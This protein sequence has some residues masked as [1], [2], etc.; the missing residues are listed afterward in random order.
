[1]IRVHVICEGQT[2]EMFVNEMLLPIFQPKGIVLVPALLGEPG[3]KGGNVKI[4][5]VVKDVRLRL[6]SDTTAYCT[7][8]IDF[9]GIST[10]F[11]GYQEASRMNQHVTKSEII[12]SEMVKVIEAEVG[13]NAMRRFIPYIQM[14]EFEAL[15]FSEPSDFAS[16][17]G[18]PDL[19]D[20]LRDIRNSFRSPEE[21]N[22]SPVTAPSK[23][24]EY[25]YPEF[26]KPIHGTFGTLEIGIDKIRTECPLFSG[27]LGQIENLTGGAMK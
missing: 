5:R 21:I 26:E 2:E 9:Y 17:I 15:L 16:A 14:Y 13:Q 22:D 25:L 4:E 1:M 11:P 10:N 8:L 6:L 24:I 18:R 3:H 7:L 20:D 27:W 23:R 12:I 19:S